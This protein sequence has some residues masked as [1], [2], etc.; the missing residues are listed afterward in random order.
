MIRTVRVNVTEF[1]LSNGELEVGGQKLELLVKQVGGA[2]TIK[3]YIH[4]V[5]LKQG[6]DARDVVYIVAPIVFRIS[7]AIVVFDPRDEKVVVDL[8][9]GVDKVGR[10]AVPGDDRKGAQT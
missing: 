3:E 2:S 6:E 10:T 8:R 4:N 7:L 5:V 1:L 9:Q